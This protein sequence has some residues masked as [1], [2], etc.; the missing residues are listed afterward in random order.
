M[1]TPLIM[2]IFIN[3]FI[4]H[5]YIY[6][7]IIY[8]KVSKEASKL[9]S[10]ILV[11]LISPSLKT[12]VFLHVLIE[13]R[14]L[15]TVMDSYYELSFNDSWYK[16]LFQIVLRSSLFFG[17]PCCQ[18]WW[19]PCCFYLLMRWREI[20]Y[21]GAGKVRALLLPFCSLVLSLLPSVYSFLE[22]IFLSC[23]YDIIKI[24]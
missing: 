11:I 1:S 24:K 6:I 9:L 14:V 12:T 2:F 19:T 7:C 5:I 4:N 16:A 10:L 22:R 23:L 15:L 18:I 20:W 13:L 21:P 17:P 3:L 8:C